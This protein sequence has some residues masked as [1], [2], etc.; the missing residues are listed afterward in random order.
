M[1]SSGDSAV[2][3]EVAIPAD[4]EDMRVS[5]RFPQLGDGE[6]M[7]ISVN[8]DY[9]EAI[10]PI[11]KF[12]GQTGVVRVILHVA[13]GSPAEVRIANLHFE[14]R[15]DASAPSTLA[16]ISTRLRVETG[17]NALIGGMIATGTASKRVIIRAI[18]PSL[19][20]LG[21][22]GALENPTLELFQGSTLLMS[23]DDWQNSGQQAEI[24]ASGFAPSN[25]AESAI[26]WVLV[27][28]Q[29]YTA[30]VRGKN[31][32]TGVGVV[33]AY[34]LD[35]GAASKLANIS[36]RGFVSTGENVMIGGMIVVGSTPANI[37]VRAIGP[38]LT[39]VGVPNAL[40]DP[41]LSLHDGNGTLIAFNNDWK[42][43]P[44]GSSQQAEIEATGI[45]PSDNLESAIVGGVP[46]GAYTAIVRGLN[47]TTGVALV[48]A[49]Q[50]Q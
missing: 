5:F 4:A 10:I 14:S 6:W 39:N 32:T 9:D 41:T 45:P 43:R 28:G 38:S 7:A 1:V 26:I 36:T 27:P 8:D 15:A 40:P 19:T 35:R 17:D 48:E 50:L 21:I 44:N 24:A 29:G 18:G 16:N 25:T 31:Q 33:E 47:D 46:P 11:S 13:S 49:Y 42:T 20:S 22:A 34:D 3:F 37:L 2:E 12:A 30:I 23:N